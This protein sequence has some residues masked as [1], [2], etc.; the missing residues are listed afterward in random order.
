[1]NVGPKRTS[2][3]PGQRLRACTG[4]SSGSPI[5][6]RLGGLGGSLWPVR[7]G[8]DKTGPLKDV[9]YDGVMT[10]ADGKGKWWEGMD[11]QN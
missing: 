2:W 10:K 7:Y 8:S 5:T 11:P 3:G 6:A 4:S 1:V 9:P